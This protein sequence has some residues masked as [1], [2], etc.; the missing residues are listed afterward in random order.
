MSISGS[1]VSGNFGSSLNKSICRAAEKLLTRGQE[2]RRI[3]PMPSPDKA[4]TITNISV[5]ACNTLIV[6]N[7]GLSPEAAWLKGG[8]E[9]K[10]IWNGHFH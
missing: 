1:H 4:V 3:H 10:E 6:T 2:R 8:G 9:P 7:P 5:R